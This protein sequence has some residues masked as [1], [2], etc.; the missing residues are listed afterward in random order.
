MYEVECQICGIKFEAKRPNRKYCDECQKHPDRRK[1]QLAKNIMRSKHATGYYDEPVEKH[2]AK[3]KTFLKLVPRYM[4]SRIMYCDT[5]KKIIEEEQES[6]IHSYKRTSYPPPQS[7]CPVCGKKYDNPQFRKA[8]CSNAC[9]ISLHDAK[10]KWIGDIE[11]KCENC[12]K[13]FT[14]HRDKYIY[15]LP[16]TCSNE[17][18]KELNAKI[19]RQRAADKRKEASERQAKAEKAQRYKLYEENGLCGYCKTSYKDCE[20]MQSNF[21]VIPE[22]AKFNMKGKIVKCPKFKPFKKVSTR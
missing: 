12:G 16:K 20:R 5:C 3:C 19:T 21:K 18:C 8:Y 9:R 17:C 14:I 1:V 11:C 13:T 15:K 7:I 6:G 22:G 10:P 4:S 2:C